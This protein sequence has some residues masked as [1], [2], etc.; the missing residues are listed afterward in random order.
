MMKFILGKKIRMTQ[1]FDKEGNQIPVT[2]VLAGPCFVTQIKTKEKDGYCALQIGF[3]KLKKPKKSKIKKPFRY[4]REFRVEDEELKKFKVGQ[5][6]NVSIFKEGEKVSVSGISKGK[7]FQGGVKRWGFS[8]RGASH[9]VKH[10]ERTLGSVGAST[11]SRVLKGKK[12]PGR[13]GGERI[14]VKNL[15]IVKVLPE[16]NLIA[17]KGAL[18]GRKGTLLE[19]KTK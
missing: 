19:I 16:K 5:E 13:M 8:G 2:L 18:P 17:I 15:E 4:L 12:M 10:E 11:P 14:T 6:I 9:G 1:I 7:G 3:E